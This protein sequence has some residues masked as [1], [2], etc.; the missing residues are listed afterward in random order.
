MGVTEAEHVGRF[1]VGR[2]LGD[3]DIEFVLGLGHR[4]VEDRTVGI[5]LQLGGDG[6]IGQ[7]FGDID[8]PDRRLHRLNQLQTRQ[9]VFIELIDHVQRHAQIVM[10]LFGSRIDARQRQ[11]GELVAALTARRKEYRPHVV[12]SAGFEGKANPRVLAIDSP[13]P[14]TVDEDLSLRSGGVVVIHRRAAV[15]DLMVK[16]QLDRAAPGVRD[17]QRGAEIRPLLPAAPVGTD[18]NRLPVAIVRRGVE[19]RLGR[20]QQLDYLS[21][22]ARTH[23]LL[24]DQ[25]QIEAQLRKLESRI[26]RHNNARY[27]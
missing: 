21:A 13:D 20:F 11:L 14:T 2:H 9:I 10:E 5:A 23:H 24:F 16:P 12:G 25:T 15:A 18:V 19:A 22:G 3:G 8:R 27:R 1:A 17:G 6:R 4:R 26:D 7:H